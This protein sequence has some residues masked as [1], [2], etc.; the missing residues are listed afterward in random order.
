MSKIQDAKTEQGYA[1]S[2]HCCANCTM[3][4]SSTRT[5]TFV[6]GQQV[7]KQANL[8]CSIGGFAVQKMGCCNKFTFKLPTKS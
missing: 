2:P 8:R 1:K 6:G 4:T 5:V 3:M 7:Q